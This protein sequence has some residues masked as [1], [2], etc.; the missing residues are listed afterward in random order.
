MQ[1][2]KHAEKIPNETKQTCLTYNH[3]NNVDL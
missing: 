3:D 2:D 1:L